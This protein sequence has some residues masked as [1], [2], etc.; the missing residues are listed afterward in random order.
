MDINYLLIPVLSGYLF[1]VQCDSFRFWILRES[2]YHLLFRSALYGM[3]FLVVVWIMFLV[4]ALFWNGTVCLLS[5]DE[6]I[7]NSRVGAPKLF[8]VWL[9]VSTLPTALAVAYVWNLCTTKKKRVAKVMEAAKRCGNLIEWT[10][11]KSLRDT[12]LV[13]LTLKTGKVY[14]G[15][16]QHCGDP[17][18]PGIPD[19]DLSIIPVVSGY[20]RE[21]QTLEVTTSHATAI[22]KIL[23]E[24]SD[25]ETP[26]GELEDLSVIIPM[27]QVAHAR[28]F[29]PEVYRRFDSVG[30]TN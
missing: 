20:R 14:I 15:F 9:T 21:N 22:R 2:G 5:T 10:V 29:D 17:T 1:L 18:P 25:S 24:E 12:K 8:D 7:I 16:A 23:D 13:E 6:C 11:R 3:L 27:D 30:H 19:S 4:G 28:L 26:I